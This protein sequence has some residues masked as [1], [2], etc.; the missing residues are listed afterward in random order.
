ME[1]GLSFFQC[2]L[3]TLRANHRTTPIHPSFPLQA[4]FQ[5]R[6]RLGR[7]TA[8]RLRVAGRQSVT[9]AQPAV[10]AVRQ[11]HARS[12][13]EPSSLDEGQAEK[14]RQLRAKTVVFLSALADK[15]LRL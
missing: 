6:A 15:E 13:L 12:M 1:L 7:H 9:S 5:Q 8:R 14:T 2:P 3:Q 4:S 10:R 11:L